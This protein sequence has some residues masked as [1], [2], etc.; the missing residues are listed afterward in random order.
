MIKLYI[1]IFC[2]LKLR[3]S[4][5]LFMVNTLLNCILCIPLKHVSL[6]EKILISIALSVVKKINLFDKTD[7][8]IL[9]RIVSTET[10]MLIIYFN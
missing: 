3:R 9:N 2:L 7:V 5:Y 1:Y 8:V 10:F 6:T 4:I